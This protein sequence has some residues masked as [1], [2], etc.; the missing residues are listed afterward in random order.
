LPYQGVKFIPKQ[1][2]KYT[3]VEPFSNARNNNNNA[4]NKTNTSLVEKKPA[5]AANN[6]RLN[7]S[8]NSTAKP[9]TSNKENSVCL[10]VSASQDTSALQNSICDNKTI[11][12]STMSNCSRKNIKPPT[13]HT[14]TRAQQR[15]KFDSYLKDKERMAE[16]IKKNLAMQKEIED[17]NEIRK[18]R[19]QLNF[20]SK[21]F[22]EMRPMEI[23]PSEKP[24]TDPKSP[25]FA[26]KS[27][28]LTKA[29]ST[30]NLS[31]L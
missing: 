5:G 11:N 2:L 24:L 4:L 6:S 28:S 22:K 20:K 23:R 9:T 15:H 7:N 29:L 13:L 8:I 19:A 21:P 30:D 14:E 26:S 16:M 12:T 25:E 31:K 17:K 3:P 18:L 27:T 1:T 10:N